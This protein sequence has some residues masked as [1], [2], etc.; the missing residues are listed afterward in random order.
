[1]ECCC[2]PRNV[3]DLLADGKI[4]Y[5]DDSE[6]HSKDQSIVPFGAQVDHLPSLA[7]DQA[8]IHQFS[9]KLLPWNFLGYALIAGEIWK[10]DVLTAVIEELEDFDASERYPRRLNAKEVLITQ[11]KGEFVFPVADGSVKLSGRDYEFQESALRR[12]QTV[13]REKE[14]VSVQILVAKW[15]S[16]NLQNRKMTQRPAN[17]FCLSRVISSTVIT[18][19]TRKTN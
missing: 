14:R 13:R 6:N 3:Q 4:P 8:R 1:M 18:L 12:E 9:K 15:K 5:K 16:L 11:R 2:Y 17:I 10:G 7:R 19:D